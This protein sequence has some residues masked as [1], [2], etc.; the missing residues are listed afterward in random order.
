MKRLFDLGVA[1]FLLLLLSPLFLVAA[2]AVKLGSRGPVFYRQTRIGRGGRD[3]RILKFRSMVADADRIGPHSTAVGDSRITGVGRVLRRTSLDELPQLWNVLRGDMSLVGP[4]P[5]L[6][7]QMGLYAPEE[8]ELRHSVRPGMTGLAQ[9]RIRHEGTIEERKALDLEYVR[10]AGLLL[11]LR[12]LLLTAAH[13]VS[14]RS[15]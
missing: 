12:I 6:P 13:V 2:F 14:K 4:R 5:D 10:R 1:G 7:E 9:V 11:D 15:Y 3:F 8:R